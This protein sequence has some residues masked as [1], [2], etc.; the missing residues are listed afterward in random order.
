MYNVSDNYKTE[1]AKNSVTTSW[2]GLITLA[3]GI[4]E[5]EIDRENI[6]QN[7]SK[8]RRQ[9]A[10]GDTLEIGNAVAAELKLGLRDTDALTISDHRYNLYEAT[11]KMWFRLYIGNSYEEVPLGIFTVT[12]C[13]YTYNSVTITA[14]DY[15]NK[16]TATIGAKLSDMTA[17]AALQNL[18]TKMG[19]T[20]GTSQAD[21]TS[22][23]NGSVTWK[24]STYS[25][26]TAIKDIIGDICACLGAN[27]IFLPSAMDGTGN[28]SASMV[29]KPFNDTSV[30]TLGA[31]ARYSSTYV[32]Y[33]ARYNKLALENK[34]G[35]TEVYTASSAGAGKL[36]TL[37][38]G[39]N[40]LLNAK[41]SSDRNT[42]ATNIINQVVQVAYGPCK[43]TVPQD[44]SI[45]I[46]DTLTV[47]GG[48]LEDPIK[49]IVTDMT[50][51]LFG[52]MQIVS[53]GGNYELS[54]NKKATKAEKA[55]SN[56]ES[57]VTNIQTNVETINNNIVTIENNV[58][59]IQGDVTNIQGDVTNIQ[60]DVTDLN[61]AVTALQQKVKIEFLLPFGINLDEV[62]DLDQGGT[63][64]N[65]L[66]FYFE[67]DNEDESVSFHAELCFNVHTFTKEVNGVTTYQDAKIT[68]VYLVDNVVTNTAVHYRGDGWTVLTLNGLIQSPSIGQHTFYVQMS[69]QGASLY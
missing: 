44:P 46:G 61:N 29:I 10:N 4:T 36:L 23:P 38:I 48:N 16:A 39:E 49:F 47:S 8:I 9:L 19:V 13:E 40:P 55:I 63:L 35:D 56:V 2:R 32:A 52:Q 57:D 59:N 15:M 26:N 69:A 62:T 25:K 28:F 67:C 33:L 37:S 14:Y 68:V 5:I 51:T 22:M 18:C 12:D 1:I 17:Y 45:D 30:R 58:T 41:S 21:I 7:T 31:G 24:T 65:V 64:Q 54:A 50:I 43:L 66:Q 27:A 3:D 6:A 60:G 20:L 53:S 34:N 42:L 11:I